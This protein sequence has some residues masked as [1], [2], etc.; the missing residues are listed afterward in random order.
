LGAFL[1]SRV[2]SDYLDYCRQLVLDEI[3]IIVPSDRR[4]TGGLYQLMLDYPLRYGKSLR[5]ALCIA[6]CR[7]TG[8]SL[9]AVLPTAAVLEL[10]H[11]AFL[12]HDDVEDQSYLRRAEATLNR[13]HGV[14][15][16]MNVGDAM[17]ALT[18]QPLLQNIERIGLGKTLRILR[19]IARM[20]RESAEGQMLELRWIST[21]AW[22][23]V[24]SDY[25]RLVHKKTGW[26]SFIAPAMLGAIIAGIGDRK[27][28]QIGRKFITL[29]VAF[30][31]QDDILN[32]IAD[33]EEYG[34]DVW[35]DLWEGK[36][37]LILI[38]ALRVAQSVDRREAIRILRKP[39]P[40]TSVS[41]KDTGLDAVA[42][43]VI[44]DLVSSGAMTEHARGTLLS[45]W[46]D[47]GSY[48][49]QQAKTLAEIEFLRD[50]VQRCDSIAYAR[51]VALRYARRFRREIG[52]VLDVLPPS[53]HRDFIADVADFTI[54][55]QL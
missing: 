28:E 42:V 8:G 3:R 12:I 5:P 53:D 43:A 29:G 25:V 9:A 33:E 14:P 34:K 16:A 39:P 44:D 41:K 18:M 55:R 1:T 38:H 50:L 40:A 7:A 20:A 46:K 37:T 45:V 31:I 52:K 48:A 4:D 19:T 24:D 51:F 17:L 27:A 47:V 11:N 32:L 23:Q 10:Y 13:L 15:T 30:Q 35:G 54:H 22:N 36:H 6:V 49:A 26:Y 2:L 21:G